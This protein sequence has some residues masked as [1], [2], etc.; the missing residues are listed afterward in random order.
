M[1]IKLILP[2]IISS[3][4]VGCASVP[5]ADQQLSK[6]VKQLTSPSEGN[7]A[8]YVYRSNSVVGA[9][10]KKDI[11]IDGE[12]LGESSR[13]VFFYKEVS[14]NQKHTI[15]TESEFSPNH[16]EINTEAGKQYFIQQ[17]IKPGVVVG[18]ANLKQVDETTGKK[19]ISEYEL[20]KSGNCSEAT[21]SLNK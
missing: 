11:W 16:L 19:A 9:S 6:Q 7:A 3:I 18:G 17:F 2:L 4:F 14:G 10:I 21:I 20:A 13:G 15:S 1:K 8:I 5:K 12:C